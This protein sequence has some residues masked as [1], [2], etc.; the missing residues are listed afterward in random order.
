M[1]TR[2]FLAVT[3]TVMLALQPGRTPLAQ[4]VYTVN[5][6]ETDLS[7]VIELVAQYTGRRILADQRARQGQVT[8]YN[9]EPLT[10]VELWQAFLEMLQ[11]NSQTAVLS[12]NGIWRIVP[13]ATLRSEASTVGGGSGSEIVTRMIEVEN[14]E[15]TQL[16]PILRPMMPQTAQLG[17]AQGS[18]MLILVD[19]ADNVERMSEVVRFVDESNAQDIEVVQLEFGSAEDVTQKITA[20]A[21]AQSGGVA[22]VQAIPDERTNRVILTGTAAQLAYYRGVAESLDQPSLQGGGSRVRYLYYALA[23]EVAEI[24]NSQFVGTQ[25]VEDAETAAD[26]TGGAVQVVPHVAT[27]SLILSAPS[28]LLQEMYSVI[29]QLDIPR[30]QV[31]IQA[32][33]VEMSESR[34]AEL[35]MTWALDGGGGD[36]AAAVT[37]FSGTIGGILQLAQISAG[38]TPDPTSISDGVVAAIGNLSDS[39]TSWAAVV[40]ALQGDSQTDV[41][42]L[43]ELVV[44][45]NQE[46]YIT[47]GQNVPFLSGSYSNAGQGGGGNPVNPF[48]TVDRQDVGTTLRIT[49]RI[50]E[51]TGMRLSIEQEVSS[52]TTSALAADVITNTRKIETEVFVNDGDVLVLGGLMDEVLRQND[53]RVPGLG[54]IPGLR[55][56][57]RGRNSER[58]KSNLMVFIRPTILRDSIDANRVTGGRYRSLQGAQNEHAEEPVPLLRDA[59]RPTLPP[60]EGQFETDELPPQPAPAPV[61]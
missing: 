23:E 35:G 20:V 4:E 55:W 12:E 6:E 24:L 45:D 57:F 61:E 26:P 7:E 50:N 42:Q 46:G 19:R 38:G 52:L 39:G 36:S 40:S 10:A 3:L 9:S 8:F 37:N 32:I 17:A 34:A 44:L 58:T 25:V 29:D 49:P 5:F 60:F 41:M 1:T 59:D 11:I 16:I 28:R 33:I 2:R 51:G 21:Q 31:H 47:V 13:D 14:L 56:L 22:S 48:N 53:Q 15:P 18:N 30:A 27:N 43:P 54:N